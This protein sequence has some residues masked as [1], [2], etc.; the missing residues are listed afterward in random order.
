VWELAAVFEG[1]VR[2]LALSF[3]GPEVSGFLKLERSRMPLGERGEGARQ[4]RGEKSSESADPVA[5]IRRQNIEPVNQYEIIRNEGLRFG[6]RLSGAWGKAEAKEG[7]KSVKSSDPSF[8]TGRT[9]W[10]AL[11]HCIREL[12]KAVSNSCASR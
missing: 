8:L 7:G 2:T 6:R 9:Q 11:F 10:C 12:Q 3:G 5:W 4:R 1:L